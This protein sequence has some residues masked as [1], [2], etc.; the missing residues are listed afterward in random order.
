MHQTTVRLNLL[1]LTIII[2]LL[3]FLKCKD[4]EKC[5]MQFFGECFNYFWTRNYVE[6]ISL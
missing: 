1:D 6:I 3:S 5:K 2:L 4:D